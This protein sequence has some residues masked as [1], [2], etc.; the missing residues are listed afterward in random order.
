ML[1]DPEKRAVYDEYGE[2]AVKEG[3]GGGGGGF[4]GGNPMDIFE[5][6]FGGGGFGGGGAAAAP[7]LWVRADAAAP[8]GAAGGESRRGRMCSTCSRLA[9]RSCTTAPPR[10]CRWI[11]M[12]CAASARGASPGPR[13]HGGA[14]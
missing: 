10:S 9:W 6:L 3:M 12:C 8:Q 5:S 11:R 2:E 14:C 1:A 13:W 4:G 7:R